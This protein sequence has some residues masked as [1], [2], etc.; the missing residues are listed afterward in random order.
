M[1]YLSIHPWFCRNIGDRLSLCL[2]SLLSVVLVANLATCQAPAPPTLQIND[3]IH[4]LLG[5]PSDAVPTPDTPDNYLIVRP[6]YAM[7][8][9]RERATANWVAWQLNESWLGQRSRPPF[10]P[11]PFLPTGW[12]QVDTNDYTGSGFNRG[13]LVPAADR[14]R[15]REDSESVF[16]MSNIIPQSP[17]N[18]QGPWADLEVYSRDLVELGNEL[19]IIAGTAGV[20]GEGERGQRDTIGRGRITVPEF[21]WKIAVIVDRPIQSLEE[22]T[23]SD[24]VIAVLM[25]NVQG[26]RQQDWREFLQTVD[27][28]EDITGYDFMTE[29]PDDLE[30]ELESKI[31]DL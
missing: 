26:I 11:D 10:T 22:V 25:P 17:D 31:Y 6:Q 12:Y 8:Y 15:R 23:A 20:G 1:R 21:V 18:N 16:Y 5:N 2:S 9:S 3:S 14:N 28:I 24:Q 27:Q 30:A 19:Y 13:H 4:L 29:L 7:S